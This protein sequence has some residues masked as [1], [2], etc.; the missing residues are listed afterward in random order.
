MELIVQKF[1]Y[2]KEQQDSNWDMYLSMGFIQDLTLIENLN[3]V[4]EIHIKKKILE[5]Q[6]LTK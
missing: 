2:M 6:K 3:L 1:Q 5:K 4:A